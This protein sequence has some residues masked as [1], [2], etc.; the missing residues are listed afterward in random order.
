MNLDLQKEWYDLAKG[1]IED[2]IVLE[3]VFQKLV[4]LYSHKN[5]HYHNLNHI[6]TMLLAANH[7]KSDLEDID[8]FKFA[9]WF[10]DAIYSVPSSKNEIHS[11]KLAVKTLKQFE[12]ITQTQLAKINQYILDTE[13]HEPTN[14]RNDSLFFLDIDMQI[15]GT[16]L[17]IYKQY[18]QNI[19]KEYHLIPSLFYTKGRKKVLKHFLEKKQLYF[20]PVFQQKFEQK[21]RQN[22]EWEIK[23]LSH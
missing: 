17:D 20:T 12:K 14:Q 19:R 7:Y 15:L 13:T 22:I 9:I 11:A 3:E 16:D 8:S 4:K 1:Y 5:R 2:A 18:S 10:H 6:E 21:A 23:F